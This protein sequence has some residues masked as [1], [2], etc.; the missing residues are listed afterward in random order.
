MNKQRYLFGLDV[1]QAHDPTALAIVEHETRTREPIYNVRELY[2]YPLGTPYPVISDQIS[3]RLRAAPLARNS[4]VAI[5]ATGVGAP[6]VDLIKSHRDIYDIY[7]ITITAGTAV[8]KTG[9][10]LT[11]P[12]RDLIT[13]TAILLQQN[14][15]RI[16]ASLRDT[17]ALLNELRNYRIKTSDS[18]HHTYAPANSSDHD[19]LLLALS[20]ALWIGEHRPA[21]IPMTTFR[22]R[23]RIPTQHD[24]FLDTW[25]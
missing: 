12:K 23:G 4:L 3:E 16:A 15:I 5:D 2:R 11:I 18:G 6:I 17:P 25:F 21:T 13:K 10:Q 8:N 7:S 14:R 19:D 9:Y 24:R 22:T 20:L 1:G